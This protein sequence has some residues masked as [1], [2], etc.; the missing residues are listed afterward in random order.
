[1]LKDIKEVNAH[2]KCLQAMLFSG[3]VVDLALGC[4]DEAQVTSSTTDRVY[5]GTRLAVSLYQRNVAKGEIGM[6]ETCTTSSAAKVHV[7][8]S[9]T[10]VRSMSALNRSNVKG[11]T[12]TTMVP[13]MTNL[14][15]S[16]LPREGTMQEGVRSMS[17]LNRSNVK[18]GTMT[19]MVPI[20][21]NLTDSVLPREGT[22]Q[23]ESRPFPQLEDGAVF[24]ELQAVGN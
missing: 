22:M 20:M 6:I 24:P 16:V 21:T 1:L 5:A 15:D 11:G 4:D 10:G 13:I 12:M 8:G 9:K 2:V 17:A 19:T 14:T 23:E 7:I 18:G 3:N